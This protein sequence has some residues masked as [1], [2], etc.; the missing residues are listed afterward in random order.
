[1]EVRM[2]NVKVLHLNA[3]AETGGG[4]VHILNVLKQMDRS[5]SIL[6]VF[7]DGLMKKKASELG[8]QV[9]LF[10]QSSRYDCLFL[11]KLAV[12]IDQESIEIIHTHGPRAN[13]MGIFIKKIRPRLKWVTTLHSNPY[14]D[15][16]GRGLKGKA[17]TWLHLQALRRP[18]HYLAIS[19]PF[20][21]LLVQ[22][23]IAPSKITVIFNGIDFNEKENSIPITR[24]S[25]GLCK[26][27][28][29]VS[30]IARLTPVKGHI[31]VLHAI[32]KLKGRY[33]QIKVLLAGDGFLEGQL[34]NKAA[35]LGIG[36]S[37]R[38]LGYRDDIG[39]LLAISDIKLLASKSESFPLVLLEA[40][41]QMLPVITT[42]VGGVK[43]LIPNSDYGWVI[44]VGCVNS[45][46]NALEEALHMKGNHILSAKGIRLYEHTSAHFTLENCVKSITGA[47]G[48][49]V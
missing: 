41:R 32:H 39:G 20:R 21:D 25:L 45:L 15:F 31:D 2:V 30:M 16:L 6:G 13:L 38:F 36:K 5:K 49:F 29:V 43:E 17:F 44:P 26:E 47:Y 35:E 19:A 34:K 7:E 18:D 42:E 3:G 24:E 33:P 14:D 40:A 27:D 28:F 8:I 48:K 23:G 9:R 1:M 37:L 11:K 10:K 12:F 4:M 22:N 46:A